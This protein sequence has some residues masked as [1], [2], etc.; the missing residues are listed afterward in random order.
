[1]YIKKDKGSPPATRC[2]L[3]GFASI[4]EDEK[5]DPDTEYHRGGRPAKQHGAPAGCG[6]RYLVPVP[7]AG[8]WQ[9]AVILLN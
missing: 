4:V 5:P 1:M 3:L 2:N 6:T 7:G 9:V 8:R